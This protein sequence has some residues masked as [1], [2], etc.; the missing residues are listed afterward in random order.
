MNYIS[1]SCI[2]CVSKWP[3]NPKLYIACKKKSTNFGQEVSLVY[4]ISSLYVLNCFKYFLIYV[5]GQ[6]VSKSQT[7]KIWN[8]SNLYALNCFKYF[9]MYILR[10][11]VSKN[12]TRK[13]LK[14]YLSSLYALNCS[15]YFGR[16]Y[17]KKS[18]KKNFELYEVF[19]C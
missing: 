10:Q 14:L 18:Y 15:K 9:L 16:K 19:M 7:R 11:N 3:I 6:N 1:Y 17:L 2:F 12:Q 5:L 13:V 8:I 4:V